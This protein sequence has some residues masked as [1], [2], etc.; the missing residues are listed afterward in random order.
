MD[1]M[2]GSPLSTLSSGSPITAELQLYFTLWLLSGAS[3]LDMIRYA[4]EVDSIQ[5]I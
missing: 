5:Q 1:L 2:R 3:Y 4:V